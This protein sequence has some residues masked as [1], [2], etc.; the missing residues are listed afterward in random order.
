MASLQQMFTDMFNDM[1]VAKTRDLVA[2]HTTAPKIAPPMPDAVAAWAK[3][4]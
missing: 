4:A 2:T 1:N 3:S